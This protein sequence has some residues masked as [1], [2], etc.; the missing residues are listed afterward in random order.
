[1]AKNMVKEYILRTLGIY[2]AVF[3]KMIKEMAKANVFS[4]I[5]KINI[6]NL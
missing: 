1:M 2:S 6:K 5:N 4:A 3:M